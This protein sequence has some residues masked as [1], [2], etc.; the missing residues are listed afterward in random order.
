MFGIDWNGDGEDSLIDDMITL[1]ILDD[2]DGG[3]GSGG[4][5]NKGGG[6]LS[7]VVLM[8]IVPAVLMGVVINLFI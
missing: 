1:E 2:E 5:G 7:C 8:M 3:R 4:G 6:C